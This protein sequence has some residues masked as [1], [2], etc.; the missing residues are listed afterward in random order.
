MVRLSDTERSILQHLCR[1]RISH[2][3]PISVVLGGKSPASALRKLIGS[4]F[5]ERMPLPG[6]GQVLIPTKKAAIALGYPPTRAHT[7][8]NARSIADTLAITWHCL[9]GSHR[10]HRLTYAE[11][12]D[13]IDAPPPRGPNFILDPLMPSV[14]RVYVANDTSTYGIERQ[15]GRAIRSASRHEALAPALESGELGILV[16]VGEPSRLAEVR[17]VLASAY[18]GCRTSVA[19]A[20]PPE[21]LADALREYEQSNA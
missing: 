3:V 7:S 18:S 14:G 17:G 13:L 9:L 15:V 11:M 16:L 10:C 6:N 4:G 19:Y 21:R 8:T 20:P 1:Y 12:T 5:V 2:V